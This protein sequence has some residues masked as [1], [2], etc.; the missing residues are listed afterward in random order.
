MIHV[1][2]IIHAMHSEQMMVDCDTGNGGCNGGMYDRAWQYIQTKGGI[3][4]SSAYA[5][6]SGPTGLVRK[7][8]SELI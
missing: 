8:I 7:L 4:K 5:Y 2:K 1:F 3:M 6:T